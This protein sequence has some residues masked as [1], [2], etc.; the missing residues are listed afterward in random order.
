[1]HPLSQNYITGLSLIQSLEL[2]FTS[3]LVKHEIPPSPHPHKLPRE[4]HGYAVTDQNGGFV[5][6]LTQTGAG[7]EGGEV[8]VGYAAKT[9]CII[10]AFIHSPLPLFPERNNQHYLFECL[11]HVGYKLYSLQ[12]FSF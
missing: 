4:T 7:D 11:C 3:T 10:T 2:G 9:Y 1:M 5:L 6:L 12:C 8:T